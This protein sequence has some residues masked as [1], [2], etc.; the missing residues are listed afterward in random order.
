MLREKGP[1]EA[2]ALRYHASYALPVFS[3]AEHTRYSVPPIRLAQ[4]DGTPVVYLPDYLSPHHRVPSALAERLDG[5]HDVFLLEH[6]G[7]GERRGVPDG[8]DTLVRAHAD[9]VRALPVRRSPV[10]V[11]F[12]AGGVIAHAVARHLAESGRPPAGAVLIDTHAGVLR[13]DDPRGSALMAAGAAL[14]EDVVAASDDSLLIAGGGYARVLEDWN[15]EPSPVPTLLLRGRP[16]PE[17]LRIAP[18]AD[19]QPRWP[20]PHEGADLT[21][22]HYSLLHRHADCTAEA[23]RAWLSRPRGRD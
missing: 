19:W 18:D 15:P 22:D 10:L 3:P 6:P 2:M 8:M 21:G 9:T 7:L 16:T 13:R 20:L 4:G 17:M 12:C 1:F 5:A 11:G 14:P 23:I